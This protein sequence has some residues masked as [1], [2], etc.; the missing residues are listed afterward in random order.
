MVGAAVDQ[1]Q[2]SSGCTA[3][4]EVLREHAVGELQPRRLTSSNMVSASISARGARCHGVMA[5]LNYYL[6]SRLV[7]LPSNGSTAASGAPT[8][9]SAAGGRNY[10]RDTAAAAAETAAATADGDGRKRGPLH[11]LS[12]EPIVG[13]L[14]LLAAGVYAASHLRHVYLALLDGGDEAAA[15][16][17]AAAEA[18]IGGNAASDQR[19]FHFRSAIFIPNIRS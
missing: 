13:G 4:T 17:A 1:S 3:R 11:G 6:Q 5:V 8:G 2:T 19:H 14:A 15:S 16:A 7:R 18:L 12:I 10:T 9:A